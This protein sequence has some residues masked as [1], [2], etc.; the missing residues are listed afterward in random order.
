MQLGSGRYVKTQLYLY[1]IYFADDDMFRPLWAIFRSQKCIMRKTIQSMIISKGACSKLSTR[2]RW[3]LRICTFTNDHTLYSLPH[4]TILCPEDG[5]QWPKHVVV[6]IINRIHT[7]L[8]FDYRPPPNCRSISLVSRRFFILSSHQCLSFPSGPLSIR[9]PH[10]IPV[11]TSLSLSLSLHS[12]YMSRPP[13]S[14]WWDHRNN[15]WWAV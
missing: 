1:P 11:C 13:Y 7:Q 6:S 5:P 15:I 4:Y 8:C 10:Q 2:S 12:C 9:S 3:K 14:S